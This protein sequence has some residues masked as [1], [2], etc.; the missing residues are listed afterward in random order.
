MVK[1]ADV[2]KGDEVEYK[3]G[4]GTVEAKVTQV[5]PSDTEK[6]IKGK[7]IKRKGSKEDPAIEVKTSKGGKALKSASEVKVK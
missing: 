6:T 3:Y 5:K 2:K 1:K 4:K 7:T